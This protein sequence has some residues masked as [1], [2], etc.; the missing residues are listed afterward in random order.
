MGQ[1]LTQKLCENIDSG[2]IVPGMQDEDMLT[3]SGMTVSEFSK[4]CRNL[5]QANLIPP[6]ETL[7]DKAAVHNARVIREALAAQSPA[8]MTSEERRQA[9]IEREAAADAR[10]AFDR[11][12]ADGVIATGEMRTNQVGFVEKHGDLTDRGGPGK[13]DRSLRC[14]PPSDGG[15]QMSN[16]RRRFSGELKAK[17]ALEALR[18]DRTLQ[19]IAS[20]HQV[21]PNQVGAWKR[22]AMEGLVEVFSKG[23]EHR[24]PR[25]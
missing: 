2:L 17:V 1:R 8:P 21:H 5:R 20:Q 13:S 14:I 19:E 16:K 25:S 15:M 23:A 3:V 6:A 18:G 4:L 10:A 24:R 22:Q 11:A 12:A 7:Q 9:R